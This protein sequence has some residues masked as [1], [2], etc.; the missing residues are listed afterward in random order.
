LALLETDSASGPGQP[1]I[2]SRVDALPQR[3]TSPSTNTPG[4]I[5]ML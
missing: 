3:M 4:V 5:R 1:S 2:F